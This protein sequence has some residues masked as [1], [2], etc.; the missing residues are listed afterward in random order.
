MAN[1][2]AK[3]L[4]QAPQPIPCPNPASDYKDVEQQMKSSLDDEKLNF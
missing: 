1:L 2:N 4:D 3:P